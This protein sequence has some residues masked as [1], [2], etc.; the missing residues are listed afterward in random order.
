M[1][2]I[3]LALAATLVAASPAAGAI[4]Q[5]NFGGL[6]RVTHINVRADATPPE[7]AVGDPVRV[8][9]TIWLGTGIDEDAFP[10]LPANYTG[11]VRLDSTGMASG[12]QGFAF[13]VDGAFIYGDSRSNPPYRGGRIQLVNGRLRGLYLFTEWEGEIAELS[14]GGFKQIY[15]DHEGAAAVWGGTWDL[16]EPVPE[17]ATWA[18]LVLGFGLAGAVVRRLRSGSPGSWPHREPERRRPQ[19]AQT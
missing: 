10:G 13:A 4:T 11:E 9:G 12:E 19:M 16:N 8:S 15:Y 1:R 3:I 18:Y 6:G 5:V 17:P 7:L 14:S 2:L